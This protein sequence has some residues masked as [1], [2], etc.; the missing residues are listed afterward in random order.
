MPGDIPLAADFDGDG[1]TDLSVFRPSTGTWYIRYSSRG[2]DP[3]APG[4]F[5]WGMPGDMPVV[6]DFDGDRR[7]DL[8]I[9]RPSTGEWFIRYSSSNYSTSGYYAW[10]APG[11]SLMSR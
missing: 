7:A 11:D 5:N 1:R 10:G 3:G 6:A 4:V 2:Y 9:F 8:T